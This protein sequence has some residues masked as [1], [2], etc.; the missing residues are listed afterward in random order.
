MLAVNDAFSRTETLAYIIAAIAFLAG[1][2]LLQSTFR[3]L[4][5]RKIRPPKGASAGRLGVV[6]TAALDGRRQLLV[7]R[8]DSVEHL[9]EIGGPNDL[10][11][12]TYFSGTGEGFDEIEEN[13]PG[14]EAPEAPGEVRFRRFRSYIQPASRIFV[15]PGL[16]PLA[17]LSGVAGAGA[18][19]ICGLFRL[20]LG[21]ADHLRLSLPIWWQ[22]QPLLGS[23]L[24]IAAAAA[25]A[26]LS[27]WLVRRFSENAA[28]S[29]IP[30]VEAVLNGELPPAPLILLPVKFFGG[31]LAIGSGFALGRE[32][33]CV[34]MGATLANLLGKTFGRNSADC[35]SLLAAGAGAGLAA[36]FNAPFAGA[37]FV[38]EELT[39]KF[40]T[41]NAVAAL[42][43]SGSAIIVA[44]LFT[45]PAPDFLVTDVPYPA[46]GD[47]LL[48]LGLGVAAGILGIVYNHVLLGALAIADRLAGWPVEI[49]AGL[50]GAA[51]GALAWCAPD[52]VG[53]GDSLT[54]G[55]LDGKAVLVVLPFV[56]VLRLFLGAASYAAGTPG[57]VFAP[58]LVLGAQM[59][60]IFG[61]LIDLGL[62]D[63]P[64]HAVAFALVG[65][66]ALFTAVVRA[67]LTGM[68][69]VTEMTDNSR[70][71][72]PMLA[73]CFSAMAVATILREP[74]LYDSLKE[75]TLAQARKKAELLSRKP[76]AEPVRIKVR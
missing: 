62:A 42:G 47:N 58:L 75:R 76:V 56:Y 14:Q 70:L 11:I 28:G 59:G 7:V 17:L 54:Q 38:L 63:P 57:G 12:E 67:P 65:M 32:G 22:D 73:A 8:R 55:A 72:L 45:G 64:T 35:L 43:A 19:L 74:P 25:A 30:H 60:F 36:A 27:A 51:V 41:R 9:V 49:R 26:A 46:L 24:L 48:C 18:G 31:V 13:G 23:G 6:K 71:L 2:H 50:V 21:K 3:W 44:R 4:F 37:V 66:A 1:A 15:G 61:G 39:R 10:V 29:G 33:P 16:I 34:Q 53:G 40:D 69:L 5:R 52:L 68:I 20:A